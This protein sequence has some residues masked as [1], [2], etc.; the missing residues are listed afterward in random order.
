MFDGSW[1]GSAEVSSNSESYSFIVEITQLERM[2]NEK[3][4]SVCV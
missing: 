1:L 2:M 4:E 3:R